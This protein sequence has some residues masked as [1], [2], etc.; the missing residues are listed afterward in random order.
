MRRHLLRVPRPPGLDLESVQ[1]VQSARPAASPVS[2][3]EGAD[4][5]GDWSDWKGGLLFAVLLLV[6]VVFWCFFVFGLNA[7]H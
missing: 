7:S 2:V 4:M 1:G 6:L 3:L 5:S